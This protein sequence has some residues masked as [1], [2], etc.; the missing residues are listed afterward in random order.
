MMRFF[1][2]WYELSPWIRAGVAIM[3]ILISTLLWFLADRF[4]PWGWAAG[5]ILLLFSGPSSTEK[6]GY[7]F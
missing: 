2:W 6:K 7:K 5:V 4:W 3:L 1:E